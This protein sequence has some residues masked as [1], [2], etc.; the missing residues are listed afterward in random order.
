MNSEDGKQPLADA[1]PVHRQERLAEIL[2]GYL[3]ATEQGKPVSP[4]QL[5]AQHPDD[6]VYLR[7]YLSGLKLFH[8]AAHD[9]TNLTAARSDSLVHQR[10]GQTIGDYRLLQEVGRGGMG[11]VYEAEQISLQRRVALK[12]LPYVAASND[13]HLQRFQ[14]ESLA[15]A[16]IEHPNIVPVYAIGEEHGVHFYAMQFIEGNSL[17]E[18]LDEQR[19][20]TRSYGSTTTIAASKGL[21]AGPWIHPRERDEIPAS[22]QAESCISL[23]GRCLRQRIQDVA[24]LGAQAADALQAAH[25]FGVVHRDVKP[26]NLLIDESDKV[27][28]TDFGLAR[29]REGSGLTQTGDILGTLRYMSPEQ[30]SG[31]GKIVD[32]RTDIFSLGVTLYEAACLQHPLGENDLATFAHGPRRTMPLRQVD[33]RIPADFETIVLKMLSEVPTERYSTAAEA[34]DDLRRFLSD[35]PIHA[36]RPSLAT[37]AGKWAKRHRLPVISAVSALAVAFVALSVALVLVSREKTHAVAHLNQ[38]KANLEQTREVL[39][40][41]GSRLA[42]QLASIPGAEGVRLQLLD[43]SLDYY[44]QFAE[45]AADD[46]ALASEVALANSKI[47]ELTARTGDKLDA[48][49]YHQRAKTTLQRLRLADPNNGDLARSLAISCNNIGILLGELGRDSEALELCSQAVAI[50][51]QLMVQE[52]ESVA[53]KADLA[54]GYTNLGLVHRSQHSLDEATSAFS[55]AVR[56]QQQVVA[57]TESEDALRQLALCY[58]NLGSIH[59]STDFE[60]AARYYGQAI[61]MQKSLVEREP[62]NLLYQKDLAGTYNNLGYLAARGKDWQNAELCYRDAI[63]IQEHLVRSAPMIANY[64][65]DLAVSQNNLGMTLTQKGKYADAKELFASAGKFQRQ[66]LEATPDDTLALAS[67]GGIYNNVGVLLERQHDYT[68]ATKA[69]AQ[70]VRYQ[71]QSFEQVPASLQTRERLSNHLFNHARCYFRLGNIDEALRL[72][73]E[74][75]DLWH[76]SPERLLNVAKQLLSYRS[77]STAL[78]DQQLLATALET[79]EQAINEGLSVDRLRDGSLDA[80]RS[81]PRFQTLI[82]DTPPRVSQNA[83]TDTPLSQGVN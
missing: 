67:L 19:G 11:V 61:A 57:Q 14:A 17:A 75:R 28:I 72:A 24:R 33:H 35:E 83:V 30:A 52:P 82:V 65:R 66:L 36:R 48:L 73:V 2:D 81:S 64:R 69:F 41:F 68:R 80:L 49:Q 71:T 15:A 46:P 78:A 59:E 40:R 38:A 76:D 56:L 42:E 43:E 37:R 34:A 47:G 58:N 25:E 26:S 39:D 32:H 12:V 31:D 63:R 9:V 5:L 20:P 3:V 10:P 45:Q 7:E 62:L 6:A 54:A 16:S 51:Q 53:H 18:L 29:C 44:Q 21:Y 8:D 79:L 22:K 13:K 77:P 74:R 27:W 60:A 55:E 23:D 1:L 50:H 70:A 4:E